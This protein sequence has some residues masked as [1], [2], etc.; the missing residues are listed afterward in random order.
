MPI[1]NGLFVVSKLVGQ[2]PIPRYTTFV[3]QTQPNQATAPDTSATPAVERVVFYDGVC[4]LCSNA[5]QFIIKN[6]PKGHFRFAALQSETGA[7]ALREFGIPDDLSTIALVERDGEQGAESTSSKVSFRSTAALRI[8]R[9]LRFPW[10]LF[11]VFI[12]IPPFLRDPV[13]NFIARNRYKW[14]GKDDSCMM[15]D[16]KLADRFI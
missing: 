1:A 5:V 4:H 14:F 13:Y 12:V 10:P 6:D 2:I 7:A 8:A 3:N 15:P 9:R 11:Y 16:P